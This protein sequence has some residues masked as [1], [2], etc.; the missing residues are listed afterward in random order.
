MNDNPIKN[1]ND[2]LMEKSIKDFGLLAF[3]T[4]PKQRAKAAR[5]M[6]NDKIAAIAKLKATQ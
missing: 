3:V 4:T 6:L 2:W 1:V 5:Q